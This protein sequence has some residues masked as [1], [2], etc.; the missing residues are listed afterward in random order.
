MSSLAD[1]KVCV[2]QLGLGCVTVVP[3][4]L[5]LCSPYGG[6]RTRCQ[7]VLPLVGL[8]IKLTSSS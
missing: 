7:S 4:G 6:Q 1:L 2:D 3:A 5:E 8:W